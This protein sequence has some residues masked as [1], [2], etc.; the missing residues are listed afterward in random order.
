MLVKLGLQ[1]TKLSPISVKAYDLSSTL[2]SRINNIFWKGL[3]SSRPFVYLST[4]FYIKVITMIN[5]QAHLYIHTCSGCCWQRERCLG[6]THTGCCSWEGVNSSELSIRA[7]SKPKLNRNMQQSNH[8]NRNGYENF[9][10][11][12]WSSIYGIL[13][14]N[15]VNPN[16]TQYLCVQSTQTH[17]T[18]KKILSNWEKKLCFY[19]LML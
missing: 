19:N 1:I 16:S 9:I 14:N 7:K 6:S 17:K 3:L 12:R 10:K 8:R 15:A 11:V 5:S 18:V 2:F 4:M 13:L